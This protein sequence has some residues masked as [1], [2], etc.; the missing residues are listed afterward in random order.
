MAGAA[1]QTRQT[2]A[3][4]GVETFDKGGVD[5]PTS[6]RSFE[7]LFNHGFLSLYNHAANIPNSSSFWL[8]NLYKRNIGPTN[9]RH[10]PGLSRQTWN[11]GAKSIQQ[12]GY[13]GVRSIHS[14]KEWA[15]QGKSAHL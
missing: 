6:L 13:V 9:Q 3:E 14:Q 11:T 1:D 5:R 8:D 12:N 4:G 2:L 7:E 15:A 10:S